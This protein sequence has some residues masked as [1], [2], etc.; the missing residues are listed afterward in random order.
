MLTRGRVALPVDTFPENVPRA[1]LN[2]YEIFLNQSEVSEELQT[3]F[4]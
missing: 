4:E 1:S 3:I 2:Q